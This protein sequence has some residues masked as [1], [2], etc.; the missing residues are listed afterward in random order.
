MKRDLGGDPFE[1]DPVPH[2]PSIPPWTRAFR[3]PVLEKIQDVLPLP[4]TIL[5]IVVDYGFHSTIC[6]RVQ[7]DLDEGPWLHVLPEGEGRPFDDILELSLDLS[8]SL[9]TVLL[10]YQRFCFEFICHGLTRRNVRN[11]RAL[12]VCEAQAWRA[13]LFLTFDGVAENSEV[14]LSLPHLHRQL[15]EALH[16]SMGVTW[17]QLQ[18]RLFVVNI[19][20]R[21][22]VRLS[23]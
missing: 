8:D 2:L 18:A 10:A 12:H 3:N 14:E 11:K 1:R 23:S 21:L 17:D 22:N 15:G 5:E 19:K 6:L 20:R 4:L 9:V 7:K 16:S 13:R